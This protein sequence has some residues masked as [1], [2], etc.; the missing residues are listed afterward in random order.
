MNAGPER[1]GED[2]AE[3]EEEKQRR[4]RRAELLARVRELNKHS[5]TWP[6]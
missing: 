6:R 5:L 2:D 1:D 3:T 4:L